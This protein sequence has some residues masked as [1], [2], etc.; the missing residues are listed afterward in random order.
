MTATITRHPDDSSLMSYASGGMAEPLAAVIAGHVSLCPHCRREVALMES[1]GGLVLADVAPATADFAMPMPVSTTTPGVALNAV[2][3]APRGLPGG[4]PVPLAM[5]YGIDL[6]TVRW[7]RLGPGVWHYPLSVS[8]GVAGDLRLLKIAA[9]R[10]MPSHGH[11]GAEL[12]LVL[13]GAYGDSTGIY[14]PGDVQDVDDDTEHR[15]IADAV[16]GCICIIASERPARF[17]GFVG[18]LFQPWT[19]L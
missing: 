14:H 4:L 16:H 5:H 11:G 15:P 18:R 3:P 1:L 17:K 6:E 8:A 7:R 2:A 12:T 19:G 13:D 9:G 10:K